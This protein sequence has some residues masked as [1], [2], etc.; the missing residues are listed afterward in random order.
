M[1]ELAIPLLTLAILVII[2]FNLVQG[3]SQWTMAFEKLAERYGGWYTSA[4]LTRPPVATFKYKD[5]DC[6]VRCRRSGRNRSAKCTEMRIAWPQIK[7][8]TMEIVAAG[9]QPR[10]RPLRNSE[11]MTSE[12]ASFDEAYHVF[13]GKRKPENAQRLMSSGVRWQIQ[14]LGALLGG[15]P[16][17]IMV[18]RGWLIIRKYQYIKHA[19]E[20]DDFT[21]FC[22][23]LFD[24]F[25]LTLSEGIEFREDLVMAAVE[26][27][28][29][30]ICSSDIEGQMV[31]CV[32]CKTPH[33]VDCWLYNTKCGMYACNETRYV[34]V[35]SGQ[36]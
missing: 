1:L 33:C 36:Q 35:G 14:Q 17:R 32:R 29:C 6:R 28:Q 8:L 5:A 10:M 22:L 15:V 11:P 27:L 13:V 30:P 34:I 21:R 2:V 31:V 3:R 7:P 23:E 24:Q 4:K 9:Q 25:T 26:E 12:D 18:D 19:E 20:L 16:I